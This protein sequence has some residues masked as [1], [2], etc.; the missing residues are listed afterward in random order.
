M[1]R[2]DLEGFIDNACPT[3][4]ACGSMVTGNSMG[5]IMEALGLTL[6][7]ASTIPARDMRQ[8]RLAEEA[9]RA[10]VELLKKDIRP[11]DIINERSIENAIRVLAATGGSTNCVLHLAALVQEMELDIDI[12]KKIDELEQYYTA[13]GSSLHPQVPSTVPELNEAGGIPAVMQELKPLLHLDVLTVTGKTLGENIA[14][15]EVL[16]S[17]I[18]R[19]LILP[20]MPR[21]A[22][23]CSMET[24]LP[25]EQ[26][27]S[28]RRWRKA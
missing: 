28:S 7:R 27:S 10:I 22:W 25:M 1:S 6:P 23:L 16:D 9:G 13:P 11:H 4:G 8:L 15:A 24:L 20:S 14:G 12:L 19:P 18:I 21:A 3:P 26:W 17:G 5:I 2:E